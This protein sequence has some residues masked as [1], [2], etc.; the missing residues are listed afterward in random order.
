MA[1]GEG[2]GSLEIAMAFG[3]NHTEGSY[4]KVSH[5]DRAYHWPKVSNI[6]PFGY[7]RRKYAARS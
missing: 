6:N 5:G 7:V 3:K 2:A 4:L 1:C